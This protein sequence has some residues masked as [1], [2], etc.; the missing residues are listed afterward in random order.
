MFLGVLVF[1]VAALSGL[2]ILG[3]AISVGS[4][5]AYDMVTLIGVGIVYSLICGV[6]ALRL[7]QFSKAVKRLQASMTLDD[8][9]SALEAQRV[10]WKFVAIVAM[11]IVFIYRTP[12]VTSF[13]KIPPIFFTSV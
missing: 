10:L 5:S 8:L 6:P 4:S 1:I 12:S 9:D 7:V 2:V 3:I 13:L 11:I